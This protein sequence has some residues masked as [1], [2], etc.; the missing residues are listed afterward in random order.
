MKD[1][2][3]VRGFYA[4]DDGTFLSANGIP[5]VTYGPGSIHHAHM[6]NEFV[7]IDEVLV[8]TKAYCLAAMEWCGVA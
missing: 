3:S 1:R 4:V 2:R 7:N 6:V 8:A 5:A